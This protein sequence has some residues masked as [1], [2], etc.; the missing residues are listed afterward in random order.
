MNM[1]YCLFQNTLRD[2]EECAERM[3][4]ELD[5]DEEERARKKLLKLCKEIADDH[6]ET[7][8]DDNKRSD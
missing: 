4:R 8:F 7:F 3:V 1:S 6:Y 2:L 5:S